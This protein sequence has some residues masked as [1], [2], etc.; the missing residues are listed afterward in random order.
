MRKPE[1]NNWLKGLL[2]IRRGNNEVIKKYEL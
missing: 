1:L 2:N